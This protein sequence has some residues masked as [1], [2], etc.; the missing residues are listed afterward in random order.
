MITIT[1]D[2]AVNGYMVSIFE[3]KDSKRYREM[4]EC[5]IDAWDIIRRHSEKQIE[6][7]LQRIKNARLDAEI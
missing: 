4:C 5:E 2:E 7:R 6:K 1:I 3:W